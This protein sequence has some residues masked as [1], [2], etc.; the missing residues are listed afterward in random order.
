MFVVKIFVG[1]YDEFYFTAVDSFIP[2]VVLT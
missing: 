1:Y 2:F